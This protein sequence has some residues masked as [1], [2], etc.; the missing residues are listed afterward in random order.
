MQLTEIIDGL[1]EYFGA[2]RVI[3]QK[4][5]LARDFVEFGSYE[6]S[7]DILTV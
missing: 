5:K 3:Q 1:E 6:A 2:N 4:L 7:G